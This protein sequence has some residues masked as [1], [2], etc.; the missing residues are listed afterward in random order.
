MYKETL[1]TVG[2]VA[3]G[4]DWETNRGSSKKVIGISG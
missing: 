4:R 1:F 3:Y 2:D